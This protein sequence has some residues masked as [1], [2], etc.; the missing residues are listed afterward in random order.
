[1]QISSISRSGW[2]SGIA[3]TSGPNRSLLVRCATAL[4][5]TLGEGAMPSGV[6]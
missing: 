3:Q 6:E 1:M 5:N 4:R 2:C